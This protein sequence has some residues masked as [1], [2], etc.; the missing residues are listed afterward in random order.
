MAI[1]YLKSLGVGTGLDTVALVTAIVDAEIAPKQSSIEARLADAEVKISGLASLK[2]AMQ[3]LQTAY[4]TLNDAREFEFTDLSSTNPGVVSAVL[5]GSSTSEG[6]H[7]L[8]VNQLA[9]A[10]VRVSDLIA[11]KTADLG[12]AGNTLSFTV[13]GSQTSISLESGDTLED[14]A[15]DINSLQGG[16]TARIVEVGADGYRLFIQSDQTGLDHSISV[17]SDLPIL[18][19]GENRNLALSAQDATFTYNGV[20]ITRGSNRIEDVIPGVTLNLL[21]VDADPAVVSLSTDKAAAANSIKNLV[22]AFNQF[23]DTMDSLLAVAD[24]SSEGGAFA[25]D[26]TIRNILVRA[27]ELFF[28]RGSAAGTNITK[29]SDLGVNVDRNGVFQVDSEV[30]NSA[31]VDHYSE[32]KQFFTAGSDDQSTF[33]NAVRGFS[34]DIVKQMQDYLGYNGLVATRLSA[35]SKVAAALA[36]DKSELDSRR[37]TLEARYTKQFT[38]M[39]QIVSE[40]NSLKDY[41][42]SQLSNLPFTAKND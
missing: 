19:L 40:M 10:E 38:T 31:L 35:N 18:G 6:R 39:N 21:S 23:S 26:P 25:S 36:D 9:Q 24:D 13:N 1:D 3:S 29:M 7:S 42:D 14:L 27:R 15:T 22:Q 2:S 37:T 17:D 12:A 41:L 8:T 32:I 16:I 34:G 30:L 28:E 33:S 11:D 4:E 5:N 20:V